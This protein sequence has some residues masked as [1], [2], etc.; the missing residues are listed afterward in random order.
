M[1]KTL[2]ILALGAVAL[3]ATACGRHHGWGS[4]DPAERAASITKLLAK[5]LDLSE[6]QKAKVQ[7]LVQALVMERESWRG[8][9][10][11]ALEELKAQFQAEKFDGPALDKAAQA[12]E[13]KLA[14]SRQLVVQKLAEFHAILT[15][16]QRAKAADLLGRLQERWQERSGKR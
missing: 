11:K 8:E 14:Q 12:R 2:I 3:V 9:G 16:A 5:K 13:A 7:P 1:R 4:Q 10:P 15:P 6:E